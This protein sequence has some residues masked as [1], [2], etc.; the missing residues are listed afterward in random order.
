LDRLTELSDDDPQVSEFAVD[1]TEQARLQIRR[2][3]GAE[4]GGTPEPE[5]LLEGLGILRMGCLQA[6]PQRKPHTVKSAL[7]VFH[8]LDRHGART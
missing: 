7:E 2:Q 1:G 3:S 4:L 5:S 8:F 6:G